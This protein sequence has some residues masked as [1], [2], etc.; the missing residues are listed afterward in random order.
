MSAYICD[1]KTIC[2]IAKAFEKYNVPFRM[3]DNGSV[4]RIIGEREIGQYLLQQNYRSV[5]YRYDSDTRIPPLN[6]VDV[7]IDE[8]IVYGC[9][10]NYNYQACETPDYEETGVYTSLLALKNELL[11]R[12]LRKLNMKAPYGYGSDTDCLRS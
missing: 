1:D 11:E 12:C 8:G 5:D 10:R 4:Y 3:I 2:A 9:I 7:P 6:Y